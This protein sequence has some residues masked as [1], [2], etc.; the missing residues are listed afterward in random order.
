MSVAA[1][2]V[3]RT[4]AEA[5]TAPAAPRGARLRR[6]L[7]SAPV[8]SLLLVVGVL[9]LLPGMGLAVTSFRTQSAYEASGWWRAVFVDPSTEQPLEKSL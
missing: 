2:T 4:A 8:N 1:P 7:R 3:D 6:L 5:A 9:W